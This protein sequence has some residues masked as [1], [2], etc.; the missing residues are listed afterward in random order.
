MREEKDHQIY[1]LVN[2]IFSHRR[3]GSLKKCH[4]ICYGNVNGSFS[5]A[6]FLVIFYNI[7]DGS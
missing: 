6:P 4:I 2:D 3:F 7:S 1:E 5:F